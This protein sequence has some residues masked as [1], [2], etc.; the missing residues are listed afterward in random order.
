VRASLGADRFRLL[1]QLLTETC[2]LGLVGGAAGLAVAVLAMKAVLVLDPA[3][4]PRAQEAALSWPVLAFTIGVS[5]GAGIV[6]GLLPAT[7]ISRVALDEVLQRWTDWDVD[8][9][10]AALSCTSTM[11]GWETLPIS[12]G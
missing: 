3:T 11:R 6:F 10:N 12:V 7:Q 1:R 9:D 2:V 4:L 8:W 5:L